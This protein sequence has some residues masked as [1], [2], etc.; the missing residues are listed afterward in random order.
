MSLWRHRR[1][2]SAKNVSTCVSLSPRLKNLWLLHHQPGA[3]WELHLWWF[4]F[5]FSVGVVDG[6]KTLEQKLKLSRLG[7][8]L[9]AGSNTVLK[10]TQPRPP[11]H[12][13]LRCLFVFFILGF[14]VDPQRTDLI[15][16]SWDDTLDMRQNTSKLEPV[17][18]TV[19]RPNYKWNNHL[20]QCRLSMI[21]VSRVSELCRNEGKFVHVQFAPLLQVQSQTPALCRELQTEGWINY[22]LV[23]VIV[24]VCV[25]ASLR[26][27]KTKELFVYNLYIFCNRNLG[28]KTRSAERLR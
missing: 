5:S 15:A 4:G 23:S 27:G 22:L 8:P 16:E 26:T 25:A 28:W 11:H 2:H 9:V 3:L 10:N 21:S 7:G 14:S 20:Y 12:I 19:K 13:F 17:P 1:W 6:E 18:L 24:C